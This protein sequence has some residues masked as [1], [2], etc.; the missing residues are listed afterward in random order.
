MASQKKVKHTNSKLSKK[1]AATPEARENQLIAAAVNLAEKQI[2]EGTASSQVI[3]HFLKLGSSK[4]RIEKEKI[5]KQVDLLEAKTEYIQ[6]TKRMEELY[7]EAIRSMRVY[8]GNG[9]P[10]DYEDVQ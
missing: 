9:A 5:Q 10:E 8:S 2:L 4:E 7:E 1:P 3:T 6:S